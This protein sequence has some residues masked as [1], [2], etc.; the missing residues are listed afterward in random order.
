MPVHSSIEV[1][2]LVASATSAQLVCATQRTYLFTFRIFFLLF[3]QQQKNSV[4]GETRSFF[5]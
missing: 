3:Q 2:I 5:Y 1:V 4:I